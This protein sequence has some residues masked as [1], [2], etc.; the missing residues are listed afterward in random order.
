VSALLASGSGLSFTN[1]VVSDN[2][3]DPGVV[4]TGEEFVAVTTGGDNNGVFP[5]HATSDLAVW[6]KLGYVFFAS[7]S[8]SGLP[9]WTDGDAG[10]FWAPEIHKL[11]GGTYALIYCARARGAVHS[12]HSI[13]VAT[14]PTAHGPWTS[15]LDGPLLSHPGPVGVIDPTLFVEDDGRVF[16]VYKVDANAVG[17][18]TQILAV[19]LDATATRVLSSEPWEL[20][21]TDQAWE[22]PLVEAPWIVRRGGQLFLFYSGNIM[23]NYAVGVARAQSMEDTAWAKLGAP[24][25]SAS[26]STGWGLVGPGH[27]SVLQLPPA[28]PGSEGSW[29]MWFHTWMGRQRS[30]NFGEPRRITQAV[31]AWD[32]ATGWPSLAVGNARPPIGPRTVPPFANVS[33][34]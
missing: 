23:D 26:N 14:A 34:V 18:L 13:G 8:S 25:V 3:P 9:A 29:V 31:L 19:Q 15:P 10:F 27:S 7:G 32:G 2:S 16:L 20:I 21:H 17:K 12:Q 4:F 6:R 22:G 24:I 1:P 11:P 5:V 30:Y 28:S 33:S